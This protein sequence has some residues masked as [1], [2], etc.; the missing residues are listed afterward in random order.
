MDFKH[1]GPRM[2]AEKV[3]S[4]PDCHEQACSNVQP[5]KYIKSV[6]QNFP[7]HMCTH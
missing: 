6:R 7:T 3:Q 2:K 1:M 5:Q 4:M